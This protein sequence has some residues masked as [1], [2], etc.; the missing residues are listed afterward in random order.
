MKHLET[1]KRDKKLA[2]I[3]VQVR[4][5]KPKREKD[6][7]FRL[8]KAVCSQ[9]LSVKAASTIWNRFLDIFPERY[10]YPLLVSGLD[11]EQMR[12]AGLSYQKSG[13][14]KA[15]AQ[16]SQAN[17]INFAYISKMSDDDIIAYLTQIKGVG[18]WTV[19]MLLMFCLGR[20]DIFPVD[21]QGILNGMR[22]LYKLKDEGRALRLKCTKIAER[23]RPYRTHACCYL[24]PYGD[25]KK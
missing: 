23:W 17:N 15:I 2:A 24:W 13:Y 20:K 16:F 21:D 19:E 7:Y 8:L 1:L 12:Q 3:L 11:I 9:Q 25:L 22:K 5:Y 6:I 4:P 10:P 14:M 18:R